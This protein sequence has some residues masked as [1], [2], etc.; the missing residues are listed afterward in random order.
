MPTEAPPKG[1]TVAGACAR[2]QVSKST[3]YRAIRAQ[4]F[5]VSTVGGRT[6]VDRASLDAW[7]AQRDAE[8][9]AVAEALGPETVGPQE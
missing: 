9:A 5:G 8:A 1:L 2:A 6:I 7:T 4:A 3:L